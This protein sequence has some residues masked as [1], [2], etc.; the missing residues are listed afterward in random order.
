LARL[1]PAFTAAVLCAAV[2]LTGGC[3]RRDAKPA[4]VSGEGLPLQSFARQWA[5]DLDLKRDALRRLHVRE[6][7][8]YA[9][10]TGGRAI[11]LA[12]D[13]GSIEFSRPIKGGGTLLHPPVVMMDKVTFSIPRRRTTA[14]DR[15]QMPVRRPNQPQVEEAPPRDVHV[16]QPVVFPTAT[17]LEIYEQHT[18]RFITA[19]DLDF[20]ARSAAV[21]KAGMMYLGAAKRGSSRG[22]SIDI[23][24][25]YVPVRWEL[26][27]PEGAVSAAP[28]LWEDAVYFASEGGEVYAVTATGRESIWPLPGGTF[29]TGAA[30]VADLQVDA[31]CVYVAS[32]D[33]KLYALNRNNGKIRWQYYGST[34]LRTA[35]AVTSDTVYQYVAGTGLVAIDKASGEYNRKPRWVAED[36][37]QFLA[38]DE[39]NAYVRSRSNRIVARDKKTGEVRFMS[40]KRSGKDEFAVFGTNT[41]K[42]DGIVYAGTKAGRVVAVRPVLKPGTVGEVVMNDQFPS[43][44]DQSMINAQ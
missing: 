13:S 6:G 34:A 11:S 21:G 31:E 28:A 25:P 18:G 4:A 14:A 27:T 39:R 32:T 36:A 42:E 44:N 5:T 33:N 35:P 17:T 3:R 38:Q 30:V 40:Q 19:N 9:Y 43:P 15:G 20:S 37:T 22:V 16:I 23:R 41:G 10:T 26:M 7:A 8:V 24:E 2:V 29:K 1:V 12:R